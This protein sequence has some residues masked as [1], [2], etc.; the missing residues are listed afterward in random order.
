VGLCHLGKACLSLLDKSPDLLFQLPSRRFEELVAEILEK[1]GYEVDL[2]PASGDGG[3]DMYAA[4]KDG[5]GK[6]LYLVECKRYTPPNKV[7]V[8]IIRASMRSF[9]P[10]RQRL[11]QSSQR[12]PSPEARESSNANRNTA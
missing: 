2:T 10:N 9:K 5:L 8:E 12:R 7:G 6:F 1:Q 3:F 4:K 11:A